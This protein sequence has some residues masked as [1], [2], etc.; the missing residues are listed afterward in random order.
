MKRVFGIVHRCGCGSEL[1]AAEWDRLRLIGVQWFDGEPPLELRDCS[2]CGGTRTVEVEEDR[3]TFLSALAVGDVTDAL[4]QL[5]GRAPETTPRTGDE[6]AD[7]LGWLLH[8]LPLCVDSGTVP[9]TPPAWIAR[10][11]GS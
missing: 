1:T 8:E 9:S 2:R 4:A 7:A 5:L 3:G 10:E 6:L 11:L